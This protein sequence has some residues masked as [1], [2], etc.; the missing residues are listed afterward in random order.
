MEKLWIE[1][2]K[3]ISKI[4]DIRIESITYSDDGTVKLILSGKPFKWYT[5]IKWKPEHISQST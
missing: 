3:Q 1:Q 4:C 2:L 5:W